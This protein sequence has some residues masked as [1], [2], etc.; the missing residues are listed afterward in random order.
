M[1]WWFVERVDSTNDLMFKAAV[2][3][4]FASSATYG[5]VWILARVVYTGAESKLGSCIL[6]QSIILAFSAGMLEIAGGL[7]FLSASGL[8]NG[9]GVI[10]YGVSAG[11][12]ALISGITCC[13]GTFCCTGGIKDRR[14]DAM[15]I[16][17]D[18][19]GGVAAETQPINRD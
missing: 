18:H 8:T 16:A 5:L 1:G 6:M 15:A 9:P 10:A 14:I 11:I 17:F 13:C 12:F 4:T 19:V 2:L 3:T 7:M